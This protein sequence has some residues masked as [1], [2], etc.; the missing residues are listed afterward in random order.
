M[1]PFSIDVPPIMY[2]RRY[3]QYLNIEIFIFDNKLSNSDYILFK[4]FTFFRFECY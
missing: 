2:L 4:F 3:E 1:I